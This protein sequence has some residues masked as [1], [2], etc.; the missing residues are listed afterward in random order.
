M[1]EPQAANARDDARGGVAP[2]EGEASR[3]ALFRDQWSVLV[4]TPQSPRRW[5]VIADAIRIADAAP[6]NAFG[7]PIVRGGE[8]WCR[9]AITALESPHGPAHA[10]RQP[11]ALPDRCLADAELLR[12]W[13]TA[14]H[15][16]ADAVVAANADGLGLVDWVEASDDSA[17]RAMDNLLTAV[18]DAGIYGVRDFRIGLHRL[19]DADSWYTGHLIV[20]RPTFGP[21][22][23]SPPLA[24]GHL[25]PAER[26]RVDGAVSVLTAIATVVNDTL[27]TCDAAQ[28]T[29]ERG[30]APRPA[31]T[32]EHAATRTQPFP[33]LSATTGT[34]GAPAPA[35]VPGEG[36]GSKDQRPPGS[37]SPTPDDR[38]RGR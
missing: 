22:L 35:S 16:Y 12:V 8:D 4:T 32:D 14:P 36:R 31:E 28:A 13:L 15:A 38:R 5:A 26:A 33:S 30:S 37:A 10:K 27:D 11:A 18:Q 1:A 6:R 21:G 20:V 17:H 23:A 24:H 34:V 29:R 19:I 25:V 3:P 9:L 2:T 7:D